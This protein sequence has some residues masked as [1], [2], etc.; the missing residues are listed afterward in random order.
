MSGKDTPC[1]RSDK[2]KCLECGTVTL[3]AEL[4]K[5]KQLRV[6]ER[7]YHCPC[8]EGL[9]I[10]VDDNAEGNLTIPH[11]ANAIIVP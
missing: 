1:K 5:V 8:N 10:V 6:G 2:I 7:F 9:I 11:H 4:P 3:V